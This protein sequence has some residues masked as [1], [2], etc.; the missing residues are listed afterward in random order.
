MPGG[1]MNE[2]TVEDCLRN[3][4]KEEL[5]CEIDFTTLKSIGEFTDAA[6]G[7]PDREIAIELY[8]AKLIGEP[9]PSAEIKHLHWIGKEDADNDRVSAIVRKRI[10]PTLVKKHILV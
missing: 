4:I 9:K 3:E 10:I 8:Q 2:S 1:Q 7:D 5:D 6:A